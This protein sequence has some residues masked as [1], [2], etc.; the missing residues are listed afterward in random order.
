MEDFERINASISARDLLHTSLRLVPLEPTP[1]MIQAALDC[2]DADPEDSAQT[3]LYY[4]YRAMLNA[5]PAAQ[6]PAYPVGYLIQSNTGKP[7]GFSTTSHLANGELPPGW[8]EE[9]LFTVKSAQLPLKEAAEPRLPEMSPQLFKVF[10]EA[11]VD[12]NP[13]LTQEHAEELATLLSAV[14]QHQRSAE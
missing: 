7:Y 8:S 9:A 1:Q 4:A 14:M 2:E 12:E 13:V 3:E 5:A 11:L 6:V 10:C